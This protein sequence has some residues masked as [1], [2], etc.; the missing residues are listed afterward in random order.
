MLL[1]FVY[2]RKIVNN[3]YLTNLTPDMEFCFKKVNGALKPVVVALS[4]FFISL[5]YYFDSQCITIS[6]QCCNLLATSMSITRK[7]FCK[8]EFHLKLLVMAVKFKWNKTV[9]PNLQIVGSEVCIIRHF[10]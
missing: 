4:T 1:L 2:H 3:F 6:F 9:N 10:S 5:E 8:A 7:K